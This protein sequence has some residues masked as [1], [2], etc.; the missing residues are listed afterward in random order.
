MKEIESNIEL[1]Q[2]SM[3]NMFSSCSS[4]TSIQDWN[5]EGVTNIS[6]MFSSCSSITSINWGIDRK[7]SRKK[8]IDNIFNK[9]GIV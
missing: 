1:V 7:E 4:I 3:S 5:F 6:N 8:A 9:K 2:D